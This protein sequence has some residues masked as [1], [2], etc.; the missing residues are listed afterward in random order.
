MAESLFPRLYAQ[1]SNVCAEQDVV[2]SWWMLTICAAGATKVKLAAPKSKYI[3]HLL[4]A[5]E[6]P[7]P[8]ALVSAGSVSW[9]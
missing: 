3:E 7:F 5:T 2:D 4:M 9:G 8:A 1:R 6:V